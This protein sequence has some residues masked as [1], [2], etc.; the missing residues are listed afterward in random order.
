MRQNKNP[1]VA[2]GARKKQ[3]G[4]GFFLPDRPYAVKPCAGCQYFRHKADGYR[5][6]LCLLTGEGTRSEALCH[7]DPEVRI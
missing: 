3:T 1:G 5:R 2:A 4:N 7:V 6:T